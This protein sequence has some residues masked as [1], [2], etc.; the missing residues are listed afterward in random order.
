MPLASV[1]SRRRGLFAIAVSLAVHGLLGLV[2]LTTGDG[3]LGGVVDSDTTV[4]GPDDHETVVVL[5]EPKPSKPL[6]VASRPPDR[7][8]E[9]TPPGP[10]PPSV[11]GAG[12]VPPATSAITQSA[13][14]S[15]EGSSLKKSGEATPLHGK[16]KPGSSVVYVLDRSSSMGTNQLLDAARASLL[17]SIRQLDSD[18]RFQIVAYNGSVSVLS[19]ETLSAKPQNL[20]RAAQWL[21]SFV[22]EGRSGHVA[23]L[24]EAFAF[25]PDVIYLL[26]D[27]DDLDDGD[28]KAISRFMKTK[29]GLIVTILGTTAVRPT[30]ETPLERF[31]R[32][33]GGEVRYIGRPGP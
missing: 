17:A 12:A 15:V 13:D 5:L 25:R 6:L 19:A 20:D 30:G 27:A 26:T 29:A 1:R 32:S 16:L 28:I 23:G 11:A 4:E 8:L 3:A 9:V 21:D 22:A 7:E 31:V 10:L 33:N 14:S 2:W 24:R 18:A